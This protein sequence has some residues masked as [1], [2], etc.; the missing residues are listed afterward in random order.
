MSEEHGVAD[1]TADHAEHCQ[2]HVSQ[3][4]RGEAAVADAQHMGH[5]FEQRP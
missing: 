5:G 2:P 3:G 1:S 4:L